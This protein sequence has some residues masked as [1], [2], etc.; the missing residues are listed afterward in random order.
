M[1]KSREYRPSIAAFLLMMAMALTTSALSFFVGPVCDDLGL[2]RGSF[3]VYYS[4]MTATGA[5][6]IPVLGQVINK[7]GVRGILLLSGIWVA[8]SLTAFS[9]SNSLWMFYA[10]AAFMGLFGTSCVSLSANVIVQQSY[11]SAKAS[12][13]LGLVMSGSGVGGMIVSLII[14][15]FIDRFGWRIGYRAVGLS[16]LL[17]LLAALLLLGK[18]EM[19]GSVGQRRTPLGGMT[20]A[21]ALK[22][23]K[24]YLLMVLIFILT[25][26]CG[27]QQQ[28]P[29][30]LAG[31]GLETAAVGGMV[32][33]F[34]AMLAVG[35]IA[36]GMVYSK[37]GPVRG[38]YLVIAVFAVGYVLLG[39]QMVYPGL[40]ALAVGMGCVT[41][42]MPILTRLACGDREFAGIWS[43]LSTAS[44]IGSMIAT[45][46]FGMVYDATGS[47]GPAMAVMPGLLGISLAALWLCF[48]KR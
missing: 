30:L 34:T 46:V 41:T 6:A 5:A 11:S 2:G 32:S 9:V 18:M 21:E 39:R 22:S 24:F 19:S 25:A 3:T 16:W 8:V 28:I 36:Q 10:A 7:R 31:F 45:P 44:S 17:L 20:R 48:R 1:E 37:I 47:Y 33:F 13:L 15:G 40:I 42:L 43:I 12:S 23:P 4:I 38:G 14:P 27:I 29:S 26:G 35:K